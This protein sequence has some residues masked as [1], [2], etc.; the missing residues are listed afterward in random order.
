MVYSDNNPLAYVTKSMKLNATGHRWVAKLAHY[1]FTLKY[2]PGSPNR[3]AGFCNQSPLRRSYKIARRSANRK[4][5]N[6]S[7][8]L[9][10]E[11]KQ[12]ILIGSLLSPV[13][14][15]HCQK[16]SMF[17]SQFSLLAD[18][19]RSADMQL[20]VPE[21]LKPIV[22]KHLHEEMG[23]L[24]ADRMVA[25]ARERFFWPRMRQEMEHYVIQV[26]CCIKK[27]KT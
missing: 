10:R 11:E 17:L 24:G 3:D 1:R 22:C 4:S 21:S 14:Q 7:E 20:V 25:L 9:W 13:I 2:R 8:K 26:C 18:D 19:I 16:G 15:M 5:L 6:P 12:E 27:K 23:H